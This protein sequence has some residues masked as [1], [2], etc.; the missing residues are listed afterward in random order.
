MPPLHPHGASKRLLSLLCN[1][2]TIDLIGY[3]DGTFGIDCDGLSIGNWQ[4]SEEVECIQVFYQVGE[5][6]EAKPC[7]VI[8]RTKYRAMAAAAMV[9]SAE[10]N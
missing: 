7:L 8:S 10:V 5:F 3:A 2:T 1:G 9:A 4:A 6:R